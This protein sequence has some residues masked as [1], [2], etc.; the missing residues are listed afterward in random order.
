MAIADFVSNMGTVEG[1]AE[2]SMFRL[3]LITEANL[4]SKVRVS[5]GYQEADENLSTVIASIHTARRSR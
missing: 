1:E 2:E 5:D 3:E 4:I